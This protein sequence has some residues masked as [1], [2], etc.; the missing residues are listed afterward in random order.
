MVFSI[1]EHISHLTLEETEFSQLGHTRRLGGP[2]L[3]KWTHFLE[4]ETE[5]FT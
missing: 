4:G 2:A 5:K 3:S 1:R